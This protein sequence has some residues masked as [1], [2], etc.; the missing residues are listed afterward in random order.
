M[1]R[2]RTGQ[3]DSRGKEEKELNHNPEGSL[4]QNKDVILAQVSQAVS[5]RA[6]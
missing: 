6:A 4:T 2:K 5:Y 1:G 3:S